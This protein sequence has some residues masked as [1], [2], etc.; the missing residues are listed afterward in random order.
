[1]KVTAAKITRRQC[2]GW[3]GS[4]LALSA[5]GGGGGAD[6]SNTLQPNWQTTA[7]ENEYFRL[8]YFL[9]S[10]SNALTPG[11]HYLFAVG[12]K[13][14]SPLASNAQTL[15]IRQLDLAQTLPPGSTGSGP[16]AVDRFLKSGRI[17]RLAILPK[18]TARSDGDHLLA[19]SYAGDGTT[20]LSSS[21]YTEWSAPISLSGLMSVNSELQQQEF[22]L[23]QS[24]DTVRYDLNR[25]WLPGASYF[26]RK[27]FAT[28][29]R[30]I[31]FDSNGSTFGDMPSP[32]NTAATTIEAF[33]TS[34]PIV[35]TSGWIND[36][37]KYQ[38]AD[39][40]IGAM[41]GVRVWVA[42]Q[43]R[44]RSASPTPQYLCFLELA[45]AIYRGGLTRKD[46][47][48]SFNNGVDA[49]NPRDHDFRYNLQAMESVRAALKF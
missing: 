41:E 34:A 49:T 32:V 27:A 42:T 6:S 24:A 44:P 17:H 14:V 31:V 12:L 39:G 47:P 36:S 38:L 25:N 21:T 7:V 26:R 18:I 19:G 15:A 30:V 28:A 1:M 13:A 11:T 20:L 48:I 2:L 5:C 8:V 43:P 23:R 37:V 4:T 46:A 3:A 29:D 16:V 22:V 10:A 9:P 40:S 33:F 35:N 45:G